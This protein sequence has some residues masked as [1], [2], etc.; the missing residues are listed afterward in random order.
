MLSLQAFQQQYLSYY[1]HITTAK[2]EAADAMEELIYNEANIT[3]KYLL[4]F[5]CKVPNAEMKQWPFSRWLREV[6]YDNVK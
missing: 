1:S 6:Y 3:R 2:M 5:Y 4:F